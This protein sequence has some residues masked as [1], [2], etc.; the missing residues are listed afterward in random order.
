MKIV[1]NKINIKPKTENAII[2][3]ISL[4]NQFK[5]NISSIF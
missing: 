2:Q 3:A 1:K 5:N 4:L